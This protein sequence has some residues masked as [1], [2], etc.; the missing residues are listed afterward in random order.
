MATKEIDWADDRLNVSV[1]KASILI[2]IS[3]PNI[4]KLIAA[5]Q[6]KGRHVGTGSQP[7]WRTSHRII[8]AYLD[9][10]PTQ[11]GPTAPDQ[12]APEGATRDA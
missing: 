10:L 3:R 8:R 7:C 6:L 12:A 9:M 2:G 4:R 5:G 1:L 11:P